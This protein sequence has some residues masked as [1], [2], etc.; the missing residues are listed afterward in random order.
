M[1]CGGRNKICMDG[2]IGIQRQAQ[3][4]NPGPFELL[5]VMAEE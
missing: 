3:Q 5:Q 2:L 4:G 1:K